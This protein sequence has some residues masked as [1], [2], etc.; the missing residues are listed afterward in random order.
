VVVVVV[1][2][3][4]TITVCWLA[5]DI[6]GVAVVVTGDLHWLWLCYWGHIAVSY[7]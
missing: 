6:V 5:F 4:V 3:A 7:S 2:A 1:V